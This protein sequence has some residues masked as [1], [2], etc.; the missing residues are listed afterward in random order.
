MTIPISINLKNITSSEIEALIDVSALNADLVPG[1]LMR[2]ETDTP[3]YAELIALE[4]LE[5]SVFLRLDVLLGEASL[6]CTQATLLNG[7]DLGGELQ[8]SL[9]QVQ[10]PLFL[11]GSFMG[12]LVK[13]GP[14]SLISG[15]SLD[16][17]H[18]A[19]VEIM[20]GLRVE[21][22]LLVVDPLGLFAFAEGYHVM[23]AGQDL[24]LSLQDFGISAFLSLVSKELPEEFRDEALSFLASAIPLTLDFIPFKY[25]LNT[26]LYAECPAKAPLIHLLYSMQAQRLFANSPE[27]VF[28]MDALV[29]DQM[30]V[31]DLS[32]VQAPWRTVF[33]DYICKALVCQKEH[34]LV[35]V[36]VYPE[37]YLPNLAHCFQKLDEA[38]YNVL[39]LTARPVDDACM[40]L[41]S[42]CFE[43]EQLLGTDETQVHLCGDMT[44]GLTV[45]ALL[46]GLGEEVVDDL[47]GDLLDVAES[48]EAVAEEELCF[49]PFPEESV[50]S[51]E[52]EALS[53][54][55]L[56]SP[57]EVEELSEA[58]DYETP[59][60]EMPLPSDELEQEMEPVDEEVF[61]LEIPD[62]EFE[63]SVPVASESPELNAEPIVSVPEDSLEVETP[64]EA[65]E[66]LAIVLDKPLPKGKR[67]EPLEIDVLEESVQEEIQTA[68]KE[69]PI[70]ENK[71][72]EIQEDDLDFDFDSSFDSE[73]APA[74]DL[75]PEIPVAELPSMN[76]VPD[77]VVE[78][79]A[80]ESIASVKELDSE[81]EAAL[82]DLFDSGTDDS[83]SSDDFD[84]D[85]EMSSEAE[86]PAT[87]GHMS[88][89][90][91][92]TDPLMPAKE[93]PVHS[94]D[95]SDAKAVI[96]KFGYEP[97]DQVSHEKYG[98]G[99]VA[100]VIPGEDRVTLNITFDE[101]GKR[102]MDAE[103]LALTKLGLEA[104]VQ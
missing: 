32:N 44:L 53:F 5:K 28:A 79:P 81:Q 58:L 99:V 36:F 13:L 48:T 91:V 100:K 9:G 22:R 54:T 46:K 73:P 64:E 74:M 59:V 61:R 60:H 33:Y 4:S 55:E 70:E 41:A 71:I 98:N 82:D 62:E 56:L 16:S 11:G 67:V 57:E 30:N 18:Q 97:G 89:T 49:T 34:E 86:M 92:E 93:V 8:A 42:N 19:L 38:E 63:L 80:Q 10:S 103:S 50:G 102:L 24:Q 66:D 27:K 35:P 17:K 104:P 25:L 85:S 84:F 101:V 20:D 40:D 90:P 65:I 77:T 1:Q 52:G 29:S 39:F 83:K 68:E 15:D 2:F 45:T 94:A 12:D 72:E 6:S 43:A 3:F 7:M 75:E 14:L 78:A 51:A 95:E 76:E 37:N 21:Q 87:A 69:V 96:E 88:S 23:N 31:L 26:K 47:E